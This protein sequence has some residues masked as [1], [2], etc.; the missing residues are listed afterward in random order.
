MKFVSPHHKQAPKI[1]EVDPIN[2]LLV[3]EKNHMHDSEYLFLFEI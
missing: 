2:L 1:N 3:D